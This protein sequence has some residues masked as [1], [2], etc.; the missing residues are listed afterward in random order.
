[1][2]G[3]RRR[4]RGRSRNATTRSFITRSKARKAIWRESART[5][6]IYLEPYGAMLKRKAVTPHNE[7]HKAFLGNAAAV[8]SDVFEPLHRDFFTLDELLDALWSNASRRKTL[9]RTALES[10][11]DAPSRASGSSA[12]TTSYFKRVRRK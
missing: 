10:P 5:G 6:R 12:A 4:R 3:M 11:A 1:M 7:S 2:T 8:I 9:R